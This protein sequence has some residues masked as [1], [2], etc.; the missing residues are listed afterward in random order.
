MD[1]APRI[2]VLDPTPIGDISATG[3]FKRMLFADWPT[4]SVFQMAV[5]AGPYDVPETFSDRD[6]GG[7]FE[8]EALARIKAFDPQV[9]YVRPEPAEIC[10]FRAILRIITALDVPVILHIMDD[11]LAGGFLPD[12]P[13]RAALTEVATYLA[14]R[15]L[16]RYTDGPAYVAEFGRKLGVP[17]EVLLN[18]VDLSDWSG[19]APQRPQSAPYTLTHMGNYDIEMSRQAVRDIAEAVELLKGEFAIQLNVYVRDYVMPTAM[20]DLAAFSRTRVTQ[21]CADFAQYVSILRTSDINLYAYN[22]D[23]ESLRYMGKGIPNKTCELLAAGRPILAYGSQAFAGLDYLRAQDA[24]W[25]TT[26]KALLADTIRRI[27]ASPS[28]K[29]ETA[30]HLALQAHDARKTRNEFQHAVQRVAAQQA[31]H[32]SR[33]GEQIMAT[34][35]S[36]IEPPL[37]T[38]R[39]ARLRRAA[40]RRIWRYTPILVL[41]AAADLCRRPTVVA[42]L[43]SLALAS[44]CAVALKMFEDLT[45]GAFGGALTWTFSATCARII[46]LVLT[47]TTTNPMGR[48]G[49]FIRTA[50]KF[51]SARW[52]FGLSVLLASLVATHAG[53]ATV[54]ATALAVSAGCSACAAGLA[55]AYARTFRLSD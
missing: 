51:Q 4:S 16:I 53:L 44:Y 48:A 34:W 7:D 17:F 14:H 50:Q 32:N 47:E 45:L 22:H 38:S 15:A 23:A 37:R 26:D 29:V 49:R 5:G 10:H 12:G 43:A 13:S 11:W 21:Q 24:A 42:T 9:L 8:E 46:E 54:A 40:F 31:L 55:Y 27:R 52:P 18:G 25:I 3:Q 19:P 2:A 6:R 28:L 35:K 20:R 30:R 33:A 36:R 41:Q 39:R 1:Q